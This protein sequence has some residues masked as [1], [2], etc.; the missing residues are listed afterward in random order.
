MAPDTFLHS[1]GAL[2]T[3]IYN[4]EREGMGWQDKGVVRYGYIS[5][6]PSF[7]FPILFSVDW[8]G[9][10]KKASVECMSICTVTV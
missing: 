2:C 7:S 1:F 9:G 8:R 6:I 5:F 4:K 3:I 10:G